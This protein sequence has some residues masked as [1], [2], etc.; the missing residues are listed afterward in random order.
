MTKLCNIMKQQG[1]DKGD[2]WHNY[3]VLYHQLFAQNRI[4]VR[5]VF[6]L[7]IGSV[8]TTIT[9]HMK[10]SYKP[11]GS[12]RGWREF[13]PN[14]EIYAADIDR[15]ILEPEDRIKKFYVDQTDSC[16]IK[17]MWDNI[18]SQQFDIIIDDGLHSYEAN[19]IFFENSYEK[20]KHNGI[21]IIED[22][23]EK[24][25]SLFDDYLSAW[26]SSL[27]FNYRMLRMR[28]H[29]NKIDNNLI[30]ITKNQMYID[31][32]DSSQELFQ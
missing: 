30:I 8:N 29:R 18:N 28:H 14:A 16:A 3:T 26:A 15:D 13:F 21:F 25:I 19:R 1:S 24:E 32:I 7:G 10:S 5:K 12:L 9:S 27:Y 6:E 11:G 22:I 23:P 2:D 17:Q 4:H 31:I 20:I